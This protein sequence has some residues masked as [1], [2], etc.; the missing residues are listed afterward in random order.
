MYIYMYIYLYKYIY[1]YMYIYIYIY[2]YTIVCKGIPAL[3]P[4]S[5]LRHPPLEPACLLFKTFV[6]PFLFSITSPMKVFQTVLTS[7]SPATSPP[8]PLRKP[9]PC[10]ILPSPFS[11]F[12]DP[13]SI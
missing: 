11:D 6:S 9:W 13:P 8:P 3:P 7:V 5:I 10:T 1:I 2:T 4:P 12:S